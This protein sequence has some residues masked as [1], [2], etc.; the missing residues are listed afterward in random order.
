MPSISDRFSAF[1]LAIAAPAAALAAG[2]LA[3]CDGQKPTAIQNELAQGGAA[4]T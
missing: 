4:P 1:V 2:L 3:G